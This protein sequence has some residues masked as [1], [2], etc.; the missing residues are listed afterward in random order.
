[1]EIVHLPAGHE[2]VEIH[3][4][5]GHRHFKRT[6]RRRVCDEACCRERASRVGEDG[7]WASHQ[8]RD[9]LRKIGG[10]VLGIVCGWR[11]VFTIAVAVEIKEHTAEFA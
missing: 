1:M 9:E 4:D 5:E 3:P 11:D 8:T 6:R 10:V 2:R 7:I